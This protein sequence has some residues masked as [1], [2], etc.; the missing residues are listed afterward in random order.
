MIKKRVKKDKTL[1]R[2]TGVLKHHANGSPLCHISYKLYIRTLTFTVL[3]IQPSSEPLTP[4]PR[5]LLKEYLNREIDMLRLE[6]T[7]PE[8]RSCA[9]VW[10]PQVLSGSRAAPHAM[11]VRGVL[12]P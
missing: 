5:T 1:T 10:G 7:N 11:G 2:Y 12:T 3:T 6:L 4:L 8:V 9:R